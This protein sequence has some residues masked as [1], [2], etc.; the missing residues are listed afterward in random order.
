MSIQMQMFFFLNSLKSLIVKIK[1][2]NEI[3]L[4]LVLLSGGPSNIS[5][6]FLQ[7]LVSSMQSQW[8]LIRLF[9]C[10]SQSIWKL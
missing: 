9:S 1:M 3:N 6:V 10:S 4:L 2:T 8:F 7:H 5:F